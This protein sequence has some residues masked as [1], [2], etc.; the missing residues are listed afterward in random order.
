MKVFEVWEAFTL[1][2]GSIPEL[3]KLRQSED[4]QRILLDFIYAR[5]G[6]TNRRARLDK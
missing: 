4:G 1:G 2:F 6:E 3:W 5:I